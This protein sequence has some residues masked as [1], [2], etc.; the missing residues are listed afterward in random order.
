M[1]LPKHKLSYLAQNPLL[2][3]P[4]KPP[5]YTLDQWYMTRRERFRFMDDQHQLAD[6]LM[7]KAERIIDE[8]SDETLKNRR[9]VD[10]QLEVKVKDIEFQK[11]TLEQQ[12]KDMEKEIEALVTYQDRIQKCQKTL[13]ANALEICQKCVIL[14]E[15]RLGFDLCHDEVEMELIR[16]IQ[17]ME[18]VQ[19]MIIRL[20]EQVKEQ[21]RRLRAMNYTLKIDLED[22]GNVLFIDQYNARLKETDLN[23]SI[24]HGNAPLNPAT[25]S[26]EEWIAQTQKN[27]DAAAKELLVGKPLRAYVDTLLNQMVEDLRTQYDTV[28]KAFMRRIGEYKETKTK[29]ENQHFETVRQVNEMQQTIYNLQ[30]ALAQKEGFMGLAHTR[31]GNRCQRANAELCRDEAEIYLVNEVATI[32]KSVTELQKMMLDAQASLRY[33]LRLQVQ[34]EEEINVKVNSLKID[35]V[36]CMTLRKSMDYHSF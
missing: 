30:A 32:Q 16:E 31:L 3:V 2:I 11:H 22:K 19:T 28:N 26:Q 14:R 6:R 13:T 23:L 8:T 9:E 24:Y 25:I 34:L 10:H 1:A 4:P 20:L 5:R 27:I 17:V 12:K 7:L 15:A 33:L 18:G 21:I 36:D 29:L 35:E